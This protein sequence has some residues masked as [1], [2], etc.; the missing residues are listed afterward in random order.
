MAT[1]QLTTVVLFDW[2]RTNYIRF[3]QQDIAKKTNIIC[4]YA[5]ISFLAL[6]TSVPL[7]IIFS[8]KIIVAVLVFAASQ[9]LFDLAQA[10]ARVEFRN[11]DFVALGFIRSI[12]SILVFFGATHFF[13]TANAGILSLA[14]AFSIGIAYNLIRMAPSAWI[15][16]WSMTTHEVKQI[17]SFGVSVSLANLLFYATQAIIRGLAIASLPG[18]QTSGGLLALDISQRIFM[19][20]GMAINLVTLQPSIRLIQDSHERHFIKSCHVQFCTMFAVI[21]P[22]A[23]I[24][25]LFQKE[26][27]DLFVNSEYLS[28][29]LLNIYIISFASAV[30]A[31]RSFAIDVGFILNGRGGPVYVGALAGFVV[32]GITYVCIFYYDSREYCMSVSILAGSLVSVITSLIMLRR[33]PNWGLPWLDTAK[34]ASASLIFILLAGLPANTPLLYIAFAIVVVSTLYVYLLGF[35]KVNAFSYI[36]PLS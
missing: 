2:I 26:F 24:F 21:F 10:H 17:A 23:G 6:A 31:F 27:T 1:S 25:M 34:I 19:S 20:I 11:R 12:A 35:L 8:Q 36:W 15:F 18:P 7:A 22:I 33:I 14:I 16:R 28:G 4:L 32:T 3:S 29:Y 5:A 13:P 9:G 30:V